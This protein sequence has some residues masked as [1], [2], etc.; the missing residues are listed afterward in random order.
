M[1]PTYLSALWVS[2]APAL[3]NHLW[4]SSI[5]TVVAWLLAWM[6]RKNQAR[7]RY[8]VWMIA[9][10]KFLI[11]FSVLMSVG[12][13]LG[14]T[15]AKP[16]ARPALAAAMEPIAQPLSVTGV[17]ATGAYFSDA[18]VTAPHQD[19]LPSILLA[20]WFLGFVAI[21]VSW[22]RSWWRIRSAVR[23]AS[24][25]APVGDVPVL[26][27]PSLIE[28]GVF[29]IVRPVLLLPESI[30]ERLSG[31]QLATIISHEMCHVRRR[32]NLTAAIHTVV[33]A[34]FWFHPAVWWI[35][36]RLL[37]ERERACDEAVL[38]SGNE[39]LLYA[40]SILNVCKFYVESPLASMSGVTGSDLKRRIVRIMSEQ[41]AGQLDLSRKLLLCVVGLA[42][43][44]VPVGFGLL[45]ITRV[46]AQANTAGAPQTIADTWQGTLHAGQD[47]RIVIKIAKGVGDA[48]TATF[49]SIDQG[50]NSVPVTKMEVNGANV[51]M[52]LAL[53]DGTYEGKLSADGN[54]INGT[55]TQG[56]KPLPLILARA[57][58]ATE[59]TIPPPEPKLPPM[60]ENASPSFE[61]A[62]IKPSKPN[63]PGKG[64]GFRG[65]RFQTFNTNMNDLIAFAYGLHAKQIIDAPAWFGTDLYDVEGKPDTAG[66]PNNKQMEVMVQKL[67]ADRCKLT[68][69]HD[70][71][72]LSVYVI[73]VAS[74]GPKMDKSTAGPNDPPAFF[75]RELG[76]LTV[77]NQTMKDF[78]TWMQSGVM[79]KPVVDQTGLTDRYDFKLKWSPDD[80]QFGQFR[81]TGAIPSRASDAA[82]APPA[83][84]TAMQE[85]IGLK[86]G[87]A[88]V[89][90][91]V[92][93]IDHVE[94]P[95]AN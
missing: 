95:S 59:W 67:L 12:A 88:K 51:K 48:Y 7:T 69:H 35:K 80:S 58:P 18:I 56:P 62:T 29:G 41:T 28:P 22:A 53:L 52:T 84:Y 68:F 75:F 31:A 55:W 14:S 17:P 5:V 19:L 89:P 83:L 1:I 6:L 40:E 66:R 50:G 25:V 27:S 13:W 60:A 30:S 63:Q 26:S 47:L 24:Q 15:A 91:D 21:I 76:D 86:M 77:R 10:L 2:I 46:H 90:D 37:D 92:I 4:Q 74:G 23:A 43:V 81:G 39:A 87:P 32:D 9:S 85:Q 57:T 16:V 38:R 64:F 65:G 54:T 44:T 71:R 70:K 93:V 33:G 34:I 82:N 42:A 45:H 20:A 72:E 78:A 49:Y 8:W 94:K 79:D 73:S 11:P 61:V 3:G 36:A